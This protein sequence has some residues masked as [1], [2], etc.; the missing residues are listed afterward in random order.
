MK[1]QIGGEYG[2]SGE[3]RGA[4]GRQEVDDK[5]E[6]KEEGMR[7]MRRRRRGRGG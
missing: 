6:E 7:R 4:G 5:D 3:E 1:K 2:M